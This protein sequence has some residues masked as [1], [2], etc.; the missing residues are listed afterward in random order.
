LGAAA[1]IYSLN[2]FLSN[3][4]ATA[5]GEHAMSAVRALLSDPVYA[6]AWAEG[7]AMSTREAIAYALSCVEPRLVQRFSP[8]V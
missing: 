5:D 6:T 2:R 4:D 1:G 7:K 3:M 8:T